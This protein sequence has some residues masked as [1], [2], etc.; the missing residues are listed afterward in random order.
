MAYGR[1]GQH[2]AAASRVL[3]KKRALRGARSSGLILGAPSV[4]AANKILLAHGHTN[5]PH[6]NQGIRHH[7]V[8]SH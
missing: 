5:A 1:V 2:A 6:F 7:N 3:E 8:A 4:S